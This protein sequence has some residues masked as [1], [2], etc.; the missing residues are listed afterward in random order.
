MATNNWLDGTA[1]WTVAGNWS[2]GLPTSDDDIVIA[3]GN[4]QV[5]NNVGTVT[6]VTD[7][8]QLQ[9]HN[10]GAL[11]VTGNVA[12][13]GFLQLD[14]FFGEGGSTLTIGGTLTNTNTVQL[15]NTGLTT[16]E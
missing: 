12:N 13:S 8:A 2:D 6:S 16:A 5:T 14:A 1:D 7:S 15:G 9:F 11:V 4:P 10:G 3:T